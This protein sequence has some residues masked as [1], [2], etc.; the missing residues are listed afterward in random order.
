VEYET[1]PA[2]AFLKE[3][4][5]YIEALDESIQ[6]C[7]HGYPTSTELSALSILAVIQANSERLELRQ[8]DHNTRSRKRSGVRQSI[9]S[10]SC[11]IASISQYCPKLFIDKRIRLGRGRNASFF[12]GAFNAS[13]HSPDRSDFSNTWHSRRFQRTGQFATELSTDE[14]RRR[15]KMGNRLCVRTTGA[16]G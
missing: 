5:T 12:F 1:E 3:T 15:E 7:A 10:S 13:V 11:N 6:A 2:E 14:Q 9:L 16:R 8:H 4:P